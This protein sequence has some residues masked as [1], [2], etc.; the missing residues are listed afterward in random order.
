MAAQILIVDDDPAIRS[1]IQEFLSMLEF[2]TFTATSAEEALD[3]LKTT[4]VDIIIVDIIMGGMDGLAMTELVK[5]NYD[6]EIIV[7]TGYIGDYSYEEAINK[8]ADDF[9]FKPVR[10]EELLLRIKRV[11][12]ERSLKKEQTKMI[13]K[14]KKIAITDNLT[15]LFNS[16]HFYDQLEN[17]INRFNRYR[18]PL[19]LLLIDID[20]FKL[21]N[22]RYGHL[23]GDKIL[24]KIGKHIT[25]C[26]RTMDTAYR[27]GGEEFTIILPETS[28]DD[29]LKVAQRICETVRDAFFSPDSETKITVS[30]GATEYTYGESMT[31]FVKRADQAMYISKDKGRNQIHRLLA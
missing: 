23:E 7:I 18:H 19:S 2:Q 3:F 16:R 27:Y 10:F 6:I 31:D 14:L 4:H 17:E 29:A 13:A 8:G 22:D 20:Y 28:C 11:L 1:S 26:L 5:E 30:I 21:F 12:K 25:S 9:V 24:T 15:K